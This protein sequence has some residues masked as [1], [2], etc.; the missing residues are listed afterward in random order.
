LRVRP[1]P[2]VLS[3]DDPER[4]NKHRGACQIDLGS[5]ADQ[6]GRVCCDMKTVDMPIMDARNI[7]AYGKNRP[8]DVRARQMRKNRL[9]HVLPP[10]IANGYRNPSELF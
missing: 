4:L 9:N 7:G 2:F 6:V 1:A 3:F 8:I 10:W 5:P